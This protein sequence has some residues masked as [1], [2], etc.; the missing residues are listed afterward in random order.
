MDITLLFKDCVKT[1]KKKNRAFGQGA[2]ES[3]KSRILR[4]RH[5]KKEFSSRSKEIIQQITRLH[6][7]LA[8][9]QQAY[10]NFSNHLAK[11][12]MTDS[13]RDKIDAGAQKIISSCSNFIIDLEQEISKEC[14]SQNQI[15][16]HQRTVVALLKDYLKEVCKLYS[17]Q[18]AIR[19]QRTVELKKLMR[20]DSDS[21]KKN[22]SQLDTQV[23]S[24][25]LEEYNEVLSPPCLL[26]DET[27]STEELQMFEQENN[28]LY[29]ELNSLTEEMRQ[30]EN[31]VV[32][33]AELQEIFT[34]KVLQQ[35]KDM[36]HI[37]ALVVG[38]NENV[39]DANDQIR[40]AIQRNAGLRVWIL[41]FLLVMSFSL[42]F[43]D[44]Y[45]D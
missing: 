2:V 12:Q 8:D 23:Q 29:N 28:E 41:F 22:L 16:E 34:E 17:K 5:S 6:E 11:T 9:H 38:T 15:N 43:L 36:N 31:K 25:N 39:K 35:D 21:P 40:K 18:R 7:F 27:L 1:I 42:L 26:E 45:N 37:A 20:I 33:I 30:I 44:W 13:E 4:I 24:E 19:V 32:K 3:D 10:L 14:K